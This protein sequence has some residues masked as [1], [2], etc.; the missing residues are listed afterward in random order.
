MDAENERRKTETSFPTHRCHHSSKN[1]QESG[2]MSSL[3]PAPT[4]HPQG[5]HH[6]SNSVRQHRAKRSGPWK[7]LHQGRVPLDQPSPG[8]DGEDEGVP[9]LPSDWASLRTAPFDVD[10]LKMRLCFPSDQGSLSQAMASLQTLTVTSA[11]SRGG[12]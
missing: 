2:G 6:T 8:K 4:P 11:A 1:N 3:P 9:W 10:S 5:H 7:M 12:W